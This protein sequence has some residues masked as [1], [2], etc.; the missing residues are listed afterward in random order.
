V[1]TLEKEELIRRLDLMEAGELDHLVEEPH[2]IVEDGVSLEVVIV[3]PET[4]EE[5]IRLR[6]KYGSPEA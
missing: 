2:L 6:E 4:Y 3:P 5:Y 1:K